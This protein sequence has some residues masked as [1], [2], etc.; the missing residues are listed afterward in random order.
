VTK[1]WL[2]RKMTSPKMRIAR[3]ILHSHNVL[4]RFT[5]Q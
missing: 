1:T 5:C 4:L 3:P 2:A